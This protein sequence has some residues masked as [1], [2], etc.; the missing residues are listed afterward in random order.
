MRKSSGPRH[1]SDL[2]L[3]IGLSLDLNSNR[4]EVFDG[5]DIDLPICLMASPA[6]CQAKFLIRVVIEIVVL[7]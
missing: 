4:F 3:V 7:S 6:T 2:P 1:A 5:R